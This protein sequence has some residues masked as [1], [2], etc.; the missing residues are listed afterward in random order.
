MND[1]NPTVPVSVQLTPSRYRDPAPLLWGVTAA[2]WLACVALVATGGMGA[3]HHDTVLSQLGPGWPGRL[4]AFAAVWTVMVAAMMLPSTVPVAR[5]FSRLNSRQ[6]RS[7]RALAAFLGAYL[8]VWIGFAGA[9][10]VFDAGIHA[11][12]QRWPWLADRPELILAGAL[13]LAGAYQFSPAKDACLRACRSPY[14]TVVLGYRRGAAGAWGLGLRHGLSCL[15]CCWALMLVMFATGVGSLLGMLLLGVLM[16]VEKTF[17]QGRRWVVPIGVGC[18][19]AA[20]LVS[21]PALAGSII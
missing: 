7:G 15:G 11:L 6:S 8:A 4:A 14:A 17:P 18:L 19:V 16:T 9:A 10:L 3:A 2:G 5:G 21:L 13:G 20:L 12:V 1:S